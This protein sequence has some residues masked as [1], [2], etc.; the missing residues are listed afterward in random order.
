MWTNICCCM[1]NDLVIDLLLF[2]LFS[3]GSRARVAPDRAPRPG[4]EHVGREERCAPSTLAGD[5]PGALA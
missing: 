3:T 4:A 5:S 1:D 2:A